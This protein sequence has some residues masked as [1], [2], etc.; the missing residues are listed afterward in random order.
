MN[1]Q[2]IQLAAG[3]SDVTLTLLKGGRIAGRVSDADNQGV[4]AEVILA[5]QLDESDPG[6]GGSIGPTDAD[7]SFH[8]EG[9]APGVYCVAASTSGGACGV[10]KGLRL[11]EGARIEDLAVHVRPGGRLRVR[12]DGPEDVVQVRV[13]DG[14]AVVALDGVERG[15]AKTWVVPEGSLQVRCTEGFGATR[16]VHMKDVTVTVGAL[17]D[18]Q[19][20]EAANDR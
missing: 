10:A 13:C 7:G 4:A 11:E 8:R 19:I 2:P 18:V 16:R 20:G 9:L 15:T 17:T 1:A 3:A 5:P 14:M 6:Y 12:Y